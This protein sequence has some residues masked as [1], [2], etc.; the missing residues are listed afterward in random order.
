MKLFKFVLIALCANLIFTSLSYSDN[1][2][3]YQVDQLKAIAEE[4]LSTYQ[5]LKSLL[6]SE[7]WINSFWENF[8]RGFLADR[9]NL[10]IDHIVGVDL[11]E[12]RDREFENEY[13]NRIYYSFQRTYLMAWTKSAL[14]LTLEDS[15][16]WD[17]IEWLFSEALNY[18]ANTPPGDTSID[19]AILMVKTSFFLKDLAQYVFYLTV[20]DPL[21]EDFIKNSALICSMEDTG[22][23]CT[24]NNDSQL[25][26]ALFSYLR[27]RYFEQ[28]ITLITSEI[29]EYD[30]VSRGIVTIDQAKNILF[31]KYRQQ[32]NILNSGLLPNVANMNSLGISFC[33]ECDFN[34]DGTIY[35]LP[36]YQ[37]FWCKVA[38]NLE[39]YLAGD[40]NKQ[41]KLLK[42]RGIGYWGALFFKFDRALIEEHMYRFNPSP[43]RADTLKVDGF[44]ST[45]EMNKVVQEWYAGSIDLA[46]LMRVID[47]WKHSIR[48]PIF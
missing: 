7:T 12:Y 19:N 25:C 4:R 10:F 11:Q 43:D 44:I 28:M 24:N 39:P 42:L 13:K 16:A 48:Q 3:I 23:A 30:K 47:L 46:E 22:T 32:R 5:D 18:V 14:L 36:F 27:D 33:P 17:A 37:Y 21:N 31:D 2:T 9:G 35:S 38:K 29:A 34:N 15:P 40:T 20:L 1:P 8:G 26:I 41:F 45:A 6:C